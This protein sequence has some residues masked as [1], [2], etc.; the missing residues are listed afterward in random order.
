M[1]T[2]S[3]FGGG[4]LA[5]LINPPYDRPDRQV[6][7]PATH[8]YLIRLESTRL[9]FTGC[10]TDEGIGGANMCQLR[11]TLIDF[12]AEVLK[13]KDKISHSTCE[14]VMLIAEELIPD[15]MPDIISRMK[16]LHLIAPKWE[17]GTSLRNPSHGTPNITI[18][19]IR[20]N[21]YLTTPFNE[22]NG[23]QIWSFESAHEYL[24]PALKVVKNA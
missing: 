11:E 5:H 4:V 9:K 20:W 6:A 22:Y 10:G 16:H 8:F 1:R 2:F 12:A 19:E 7:T 17:V 14:K 18:L 13:N 15:V 23:N 3:M 21:G 24:V